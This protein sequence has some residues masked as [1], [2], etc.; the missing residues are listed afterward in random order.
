[1]QLR[2]TKSMN[3]ASPK[4]RIGTRGSRLAR[5]QADQVCS[6]LCR[7]HSLDISD[8]EIIP[9]STSGDRL[10]DVP[11][12]D[13]GGKGLFVKEI[14]RA[15]LDNEIDLAVHSLKDMSAHLPTG[16]TLASFLPRVDPRDAFI[17]PSSKD[18]SDLPEN[19]CLGSSSVRRKALVHRVRP[20]IDVVAFRGNVTTRLDKLSEGRVSATLLASAGLHRLDMSDKITSYLDPDDFPPSPC[21]GVIGIEVRDGD[22]KHKSLVS[23]LN[24][25]STHLEVSLERGFLAT[26]DGSCRTPISGLARY[27]GK[28]VTFHGLILSVC[29]QQSYDWRGDCTGDLRDAYELGKTAG[30]SLREQAGEEFFHHWTDS[31]SDA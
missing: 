7:V 11:L 2:F 26:L 9:I 31:P 28:R 12:A 16:L 22:T 13:F 10:V 8:F 1:M 30:L 3:M 25:E 19:S 27:D 5:I 18:L 15:L 17:S 14:E 21:Q 23:A 20:D 24:D 29:G 4:I 6:E